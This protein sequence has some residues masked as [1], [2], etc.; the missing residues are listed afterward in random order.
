[1]ILYT[2]VLTLNPKETSGIVAITL[3]RK[4]AK[5]LGERLDKIEKDYYR[6]NRVHLDYFQLMDEGHAISAND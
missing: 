3:E 4:K 5:Y 2:E 1:M 6:E